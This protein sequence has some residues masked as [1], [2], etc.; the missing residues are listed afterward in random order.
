MD[1][2]FLEP[3]CL[4]VAAQAVGIAK[5]FVELYGVGISAGEEFIEVLEPVHFCLRGTVD[6]ISDMTGITLRFLDVV[7]L[8]VDRG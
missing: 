7:I 3:L 4:Q 5:G 1:F 6:P 8:V 2:V